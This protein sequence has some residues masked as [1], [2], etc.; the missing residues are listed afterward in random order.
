MK[1]FFIFL[2]ILI[3]SKEHLLFEEESIVISGVLFFVYLFYIAYADILAEAFG[4]RG[5]RILEVAAMAFDPY[6]AIATY[7]ATFHRKA[8]R[9]NRFFDLYFFRI[10]K[11]FK[12]MKERH[13]DID[14]QHVHD[15]ITIEYLVSLYVGELDFLCFNGL[16]VTDLS[17]L[18]TLLRD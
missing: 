13:P 14:A 15:F 12:R 1:F 5:K 9:F 4:H 2:L 17:V 11:R 10:L 7:L 18:E 8:S 6:H 3:I 16:L